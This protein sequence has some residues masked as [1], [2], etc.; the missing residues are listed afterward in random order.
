M[1]A[2]HSL[3]GFKRD[4]EVWLVVSITVSVF[5][6]TNLPNNTC[7]RDFDGYGDTRSFDDDL[8]GFVFIQFN[9]HLCCF[10]VGGKYWSRTNDRRIMSP[11]L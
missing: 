10:Q 2:Q 9:L 1:S 4:P 3:C 8:N 6:D 7:L 5:R 11:L